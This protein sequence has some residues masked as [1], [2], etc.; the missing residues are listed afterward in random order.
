MMIP[1]LHAGQQFIGLV[2]SM[3]DWWQIHTSLESAEMSRVTCVPLMI[4]LAACFT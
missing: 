4:D 3:T 1:Q 2:L